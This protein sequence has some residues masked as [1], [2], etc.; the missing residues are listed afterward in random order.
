MLCTAGSLENAYQQTLKSFTAVDGVSMCDLGA[1]YW[2]KGKKARNAQK[3]HFCKV[4]FGTSVSLQ[5]TAKGACFK[6]ITMVA[7][8]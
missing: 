8:P 1:G 3:R 6:V 5:N 7:Y 2:E 4:N